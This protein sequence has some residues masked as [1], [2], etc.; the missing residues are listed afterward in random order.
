[1]EFLG[2][3]FWGKWIRRYVDELAIFSEEQVK[4]WSEG[5]GELLSKTRNVD[6]FRELCA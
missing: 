2:V 1:M 6:S 3:R 5:D 4:L